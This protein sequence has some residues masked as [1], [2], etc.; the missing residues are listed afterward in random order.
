MGQE[1]DWTDPGEVHQM[2]EQFSYDCF[3]QR[4]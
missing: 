3:S 2:N 1:M 4:G